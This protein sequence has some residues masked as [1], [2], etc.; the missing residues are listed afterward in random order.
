MDE[1][2]SGLIVVVAVNTFHATR[3]PTELPDTGARS[4][5]KVYPVGTVIVPDPE[6]YTADV[7][8]TVLACVG[9]MLPDGRVVHAVSSS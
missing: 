2:H 7:T 5:A 6:S 1:V 4:A 8:E 3:I 9:V